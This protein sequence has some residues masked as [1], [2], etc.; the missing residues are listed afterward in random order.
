MRHR[1]YGKAYPVSKGILLG[2]L[3]GLASTTVLVLVQACSQLVPDPS[4]RAKANA[5]HVLAEVQQVSE[6]VK[7]VKDGPVTCYMFR[8][9]ISCVRVGYE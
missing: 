5:E 7:K 9:S 4:P 6:W 3:F 8:D 2:S 1:C